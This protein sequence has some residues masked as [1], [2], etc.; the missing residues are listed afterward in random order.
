MKVNQLFGGKHRSIY[1]SKFKSSKKIAW[2]E[3]QVEHFD[4]E[5]GG[6]ISLGNVG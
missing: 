3:E 4:P 6:D 2:S 1:G 5:D